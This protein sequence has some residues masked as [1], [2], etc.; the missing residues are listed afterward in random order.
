M[1]A[2]GHHSTFFVEMTNRFLNK[3]LSV[4]DNNT[5]L[6]MIFT[7]G[8]FTASYAWNSSSVATTDVDISL[9]VVGR[10]YHLLISFQA[11]L[12]ITY[13]LSDSEV[14]TYT[15]NVTTLLIKSKEIYRIHI[16]KHRAMHR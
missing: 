16:E 5:I 9:L 10:G 11:I 12:Y 7:E 6:N 15:Q 8:S 14:K 2:R 13:N 1:C 4:L 3:V